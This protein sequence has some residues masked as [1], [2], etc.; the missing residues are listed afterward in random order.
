MD[1]S[2]LP[3]EKQNPK[4][5]S[6]DSLSV[7]KILNLMDE[8]DRSV[9]RAV[10]RVSA[11]LAR[12]VRMIVNALKA[13]GR[14]FFFG[15][16]TSGRLGVLE[17]AECP[18]TFNTPPHLAQALIAGGKRAVF[19]SQEGAEDRAQEARREVRKRVR[20]GDVVVGI[21]ASGVTPFVQG[22]LQESKR[23]GART[24]LVACNHSSPLR[25]YVDLLIAPKVGPEVISGSTRLK[26]G[27]ATK[28]ILNR[29]TVTSMVQLGKV[30]GNWMV[31]LQPRSQKLK[32]RA[33]RIVRKLTGLSEKK[34]KGLL[35]KARGHVK[36][37]ILMNR[38]CLSFL[39][40]RELLRKKDGF[41][42]KA[43]DGNASL[44]GS[45]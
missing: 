41:L 14:L 11:S 34:A 25:S 43:L 1:Y 37:A 44:R 13:G 35:K 7:K 31:D 2:R 24:I 40:A 36:T 22:A 23:R 19:R 9:P 4:T 8:E 29:L 17:A 28:L 6:L 5:T 21:T 45:Q 27:T 10:K 39:E 15:A 18:P 20:K 3:T 12:G 38:K 16:G 33:L 26:A 30:Y 32:A 42:R